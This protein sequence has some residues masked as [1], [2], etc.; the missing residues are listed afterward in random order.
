MKQKKEGI[1][2]AQI[3][4]VGNFK[5]GV[6]KTTVCVLFS[7]LLEKSKRKTLLIDFD[8]QAN[9]TEIVEATY[10]DTKL[11]SEIDSL[12]PLKKGSFKSH[13]IEVSDYLSIVPADW[14]LSKFPDFIEDFKKEE[15]NYLL[16]Y[17]IKEIKDDYDYIIID[18]PPTLSYFTNNAILASD[19][20]IM[21]LQTQQQAFSSSLKFISYLK[22]LK[23]DYH[24]N[25][26][27]LGVVQYLVK[28]DGKVDNEIIKISNETFGDAI[29]SHQIHQ[30]ERV[31]RFGK[32]GIKDND[33][34]DE[35]V[36]FMYSELLSETIERINEFN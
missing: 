18:V 32:N 5:G 27:L 12:Q 9:S 25:F 35:R 15:R 19:Y 13:I 6:G 14:N 33:L 16:Q 22:D 10:P 3:I 29:F 20:V 28:K 30:R 17:M 36:L 26:E 8:P 1:N 11:E 34:H 31:K 4:T 24:S 21:V 7:Y 2:M 23:S